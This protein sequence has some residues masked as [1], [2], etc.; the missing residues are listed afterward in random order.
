MAN[1]FTSLHDH[2]AFSTKSRERRLHAEIEDEHRKSLHV[3]EI[4]AEEKY[5]F[6]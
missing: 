6:G 3:H 2:L 1:T 5:A 4:V